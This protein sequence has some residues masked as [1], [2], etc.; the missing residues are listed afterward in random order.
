MLKTIKTGILI[1]IILLL[2][3]SVNAQQTQNQQSKTEKNMKQILIDKVTVPASSKEEFLPRMNMSR[4]F[5]KKQPGFI[6]DEFFEQADE[7]GDLI[8]ITIVVW[9]NAEAFDKARHAVQ[10][11]YQRE[12]FDLLGFCKR[13]NI[14]LERNGIYHYYMIN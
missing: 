11:E 3:A 2:N 13:L 5:V 7:H 9:E 6:K 1:G 14:K 12:G 10:S 8:Y 4:E